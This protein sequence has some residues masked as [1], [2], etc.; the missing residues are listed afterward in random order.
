MLYI[1]KLQGQARKI[2]V[3]ACSEKAEYLPDTPDDE[4]PD[5]EA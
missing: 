3:K 5:D 1:R 2:M 4:H